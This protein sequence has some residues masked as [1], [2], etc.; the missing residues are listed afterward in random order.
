LI[1]SDRAEKDN[2][3]DYSEYV[4]NYTSRNLS[5]NADILAAFAGVTNVLSMQLQTNFLYGH[6]ERY[7]YTS[8]LWTSVEELGKRVETPEIPS[9]SW[10][11][12]LGKKSYERTDAGQDLND[13]GTLVRFHAIDANGCLKQLQVDERWF[14]G[15]LEASRDHRLDELPAMDLR[16]QSWSFPKSAE[17]TAF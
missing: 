15:S 10:A 5:F 1:T 12:W 13:A 3:K 16:E 17:A 11:A 6:P 9:W 14:G 8:L 2:T 4:E 7:F